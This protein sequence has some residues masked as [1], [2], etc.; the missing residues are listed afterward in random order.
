MYKRILAYLLILC[1]SFGCISVQADENSGVVFLTNEKVIA[2]NTVEVDLVLDSNCGFVNLG[3]EIIYDDTV[4]NLVD[5]KVNKSIG[6]T[7]TTAQSIDKIPYNIGWDCT[8]NNYFN[9]NLAT[10]IFEVNEN[11]KNGDYLVFVDYYKGRNGN[12][13]DGISV[14]YDEYDNPLNLQYR[15][16]MIHV[17][18]TPIRPPSSGGGGGGSEL[19][20]NTVSA[21]L[22][23]ASGR[24]GD[25][26]DVTLG[27]FNNTGFANLG[28]EVDYDADVM[29][30][31]TVNNNHSVGATFTSAQRF[32]SK[33]YNFG[34]DSISNVYYNGNLATLSFKIAD[35]APTGY[36]PVM[37]SY[38]KGRDG[39]YIDGESVN[40]DENEN[41]L[42][43]QY[44]NGV[45]EVTD[46]NITDDNYWVEFVS[47]KDTYSIGEEFDV[48]V[49][50]HTNDSVLEIFEDEY[51]VSGFDSS[52]A[53]HCSVTVSYEGFSRVF[54]VDVVDNKPIKPVITYVARADCSGG[55]SITPYGYTTVKEGSILKYMVAVQDGYT[56][57]SVTVNGEYVNCY[58]GTLELTVNGDTVIM[59]SAIKKTFT[60]ETEVQGN[61]RVELSDNEVEY[62]DG[63][64]AVFIPDDGYIVTDVIVDGKSVGACRS[65][66]FNEI[67]DNHT[68][69]AIFE[70][71]IQ[72]VNVIAVSG[73]GGTVY[74][75]K[76]VVNSGAGAKFTVTP[77]YG[78]HISEAMLNGELINFDDNEIILDSVTADSHLS[79]NFEKDLFEVATTTSDGVYM[80]TV[81]NGYSD[82]SAYVPY[83]DKIQVVVEVEDGYKLNNLYV[84]SNPV[85]FEKTDNG[86]VYTLTVKEN[87]IITARCGRNFVSKYNSDVADAGLPAFINAENAYDKLVE[88]EN[89]AKQYFEL[90]DEEK[91]VCTS[92][93]ATVLDAI[94]RAKAYI[95]LSDSGIVSTIANLPS[96]DKITSS[97]YRV[98]KKRIE[99]AYNTYETLT[100]LSKSLIDYNYSAKL[101]S[102]KEKSDMLYR[103]S[104]NV[105]A[106][107][108]ELVESVP[109]GE[110]SADNL[111]V[112][113]SSLMLAEKTYADMN[114]SDK[115]QVSDELLT[116]MFTKNGNIAS[117][118]QKSFATPFTS[119]VLR[120]SHIE[121]SDDVE[122]AEAK[123]ATIYELMNVYHSFPTYILEQIPSDTV[124]RLNS[125]FDSASIKVESEV[126]NIPVDMHGDFGEETK[127]V[128]TDPE[129]DKQHIS[130]T[131]GKSLYQAFDVK[132]YAD[133]VA[134]QPTSKIRIRLE[135]NKAVSEANVSVVYI[136]DDGNIFDVQGNVSQ[137]N[138]R[139]Y[140]TFFIDHFSTFA[141]V[142]DDNAAEKADVVFDSDYVLEGESLT[143]TVG[144]AVNAS[145]CNLW[146]AGYTSEGDITFIEKSSDG[147]VSATVA[148]NTDTVKAMLWS[149]NMTPITGVKEISIV[150]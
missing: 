10:L 139:Y 57:D 52:F 110:I 8:D 133:N 20:D 115:E 37:L 13:I 26:V 99:T 103:E 43:I 76:A 58:N 104:M 78:Y 18:N 150:K 124:H 121:V 141:V 15:E 112:A 95:A 100:N 79:V 122:T 56:L 117:A 12:Y 127:V 77:D 46:D 97:N 140:M 3:F 148:D 135:I 136:D 82:I 51:T 96:T 84:N 34:W 2:G 71:I 42:C 138:G 91:L 143:A 33:P 102:L 107:L 9:G 87:A 83:M 64:T 137:E 105:I 80:Y 142:Y 60:I 130:D 54:E 66:K 72:T 23:S 86:Y 30:L 90:N 62:G 27:L 109:E 149:K 36:Y 4:M 14:N 88:F 55:A 28:F 81:Y 89:L 6:A 35:D 47:A 50:L 118:I 145:G 22:S 65:Y 128:L 16:G 59:V 120:T 101:K 111:S 146:M 125:L 67:N 119:K 38:Y 69:S 53:G 70:R 68:V 108:A 44:F 7:C 39:N 31:I 32:E 92:A 132:L 61:G 21:I 40:Y 19:P 131:T 129:P 147:S 116:D 123:R 114:E 17:E 45:I 98:Y 126:N 144:G 73:K 63:C 93:Y 5:V 25:V 106:Y 74:P 11:T 113:Y 49:W 48:Q 75:A 94:D 1:L 24:S 29:S 134:V 41:P 85:K